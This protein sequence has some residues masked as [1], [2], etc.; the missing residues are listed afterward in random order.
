MAS[1]KALKKRIVSVKSTQKITKAMKLVSAAKLRRA[2]EK[3]QAS[4]PYEQELV[5]IVSSLMSNTVW[6]SPLRE[7]RQVKKTALVVVSTDRGLCGSL[8]TNNFK[9]ALRRARELPQGTVEIFALGKKSADFFRRRGLSV[10]ATYLDMAR[11]GNFE[12]AKKVSAEISEAFLSGRF[13]RIEV[14][15]TRFE[16]AISQKPSS[17]LLLPFLP[18]EDQSK[19]NFLCEPSAEQLLTSLVP[20]LIGFRVY[21]AILESVASEFGARMAAMESATKNAKDVIERLT[22]ERNRARQAAITK[23]LMEIIGGAEALSA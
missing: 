11:N 20:E 1:L 22:L 9:Q 19:K 5:S 7:E 12:F 2:A 16:S 3:A 8:N 15:Y 10:A 21:R 13:D 6:E 23:E 18:P 17:F 14:F 4:R